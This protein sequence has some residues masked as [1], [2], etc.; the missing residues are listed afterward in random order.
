MLQKLKKIFNPR[1]SHLINDVSNQ[2]NDF[3]NDDREIYNIV[4]P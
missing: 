4:K 3:S 1:S 2:Y